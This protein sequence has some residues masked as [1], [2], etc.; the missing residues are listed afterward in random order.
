MIGICALYDIKTELLESHIYPK[1]VIKHTK[2]TGSS[3]LRNFVEPNK[4]AQDGPK[5]NLLSFKAEQ[6][7]SIREKWFAENIFVPYL[8]GEYSLKYDQNLYYFAMSFLWRIIHLQFRNNDLTKKWH[9]DKLLEVE[10]EW[11]K[12]LTKTVIPENFHNVNIL[13]TDRIENNNSDIKGADF[14]LTRTLDAT[15]VDNNSQSFL[16]IYGKFNRFIFYSVIKSPPINDELYDVEINPNGG[17]LEVP[18][19]INY[20]PINSFLSNRMKGLEKLPKSSDFQQGI[21]EKEILKDPEK[22]WNSDL[23]QSLYNDI[24]L[25]I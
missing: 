19:G 13:L 22:F 3:Y 6:E 4:R 16:I 2:K 7:F 23:G 14:Y 5:I 1:F 9:F 20:F 15:I 17:T 12:Y 25:D 24:N 18:Q 8:R 10:K 11:K 21:I